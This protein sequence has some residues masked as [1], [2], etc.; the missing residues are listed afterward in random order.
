MTTIQ[1]AAVGRGYARAVFSARQ[2]GHVLPLELVT[3]HLR[4]VVRSIRG[5]W[6]AR[7]A[8]EMRSYLVSEPAEIEPV[9]AVWSDNR[10][11]HRELL[12]RLCTSGGSAPAEFADGPLDAPDFMPA[13]AMYSVLCL[14]RVPQMVVARP[15]VMAFWL[16]WPHG[17]S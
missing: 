2:H 15:T 7:I 17:A 3:S 6:R 14:I 16:W 1:H 12:D 11:R 8:A 4:A 10:G 9:P 13:G 5:N